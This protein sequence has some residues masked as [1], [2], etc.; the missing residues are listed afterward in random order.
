MVVGA[1]LEV[2]GEDV[3]QGRRILVRAE[4]CAQVGVVRDVLRGIESVGG[5]VFPVSRKNVVGGADVLRMRALRD[6]EV[7]GFDEIV[8]GRDVLQSVEGG[9]AALEQPVLGKMRLSGCGVRT[10][11]PDPPGNCVR[12]WA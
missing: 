1:P 6:T 8:V 4:G 10:E 7:K 3:M 9:G 12:L 5:A 2:A 11:R